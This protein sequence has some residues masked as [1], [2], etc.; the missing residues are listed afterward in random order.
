MHPEATNLPGVLESLDG[1]RDFD[2]RQVSVL[3]PTLAATSQLVV[4][5]ES[6]TAR[7]PTPLTQT[8][9]Q[10]QAQTKT[11]D[12]QT[13]RQTDAADCD[14]SQ[15]GKRAPS[16]GSSQESEDDAQSKRIR[17][18]EDD[19]H[20][21]A[22]RTR[23]SAAPAATHNAAHAALNV[24]DKAAPARGEGGKCDVNGGEGGGRPQTRHGGT[25]NSEHH[26]PTSAPD[27]GAAVRLKKEKMHSALPVP[28]AEIESKQDLTTPKS[29]F[30]V[31]DKV[32]AWFKPEKGW[33]EA[34]VAERL[35]DGGFLLDW[36]DGDEADRFKRASN[37]RHHG[38]MRSDPD[39]EPEPLPTPQKNTPKTRCMR[40]ES[41]RREESKV[42][43]ESKTECTDLVPAEHKAGKQ[44]VA[45]ASVAVKRERPH[46]DDKQDAEECVG[47]RGGQEEGASRK[48]AAP[49]RFR[50]GRESSFKCVTVQHDQHALAAYMP[51][52]GVQ[53]STKVS[54]PSHTSSAAVSGGADFFR[55]G[56]LVLVS[57]AAQSVLRNVKKAGKD[58]TEP[59]GKQALS[60][61]MGPFEVERAVSRDAVCGGE[62]GWAYRL[63]IPRGKGRV[64]FS[65]SIV[66]GDLGVHGC[67]FDAEALR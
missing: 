5:V 15:T 43:E 61:F 25:A 16:Q 22:R 54:T 7:N 24:S 50:A 21:H 18:M 64:L 9:T 67:E 59:F 58:A 41:K 11:K 35:E 66:D 6:D 57:T 52:G 65:G 4:K 19:T 36:N 40:E 49:E 48:R 47:G 63:K 37:L 14:S 34:S 2:S 27:K 29:S 42:R 8:Q 60:R 31:G 33:Y 55:A 1:V 17:T 44:T 23:H 10:T 12:A 32:W 38:K 20:H 45:H 46:D 39:D 30:Q 26:I 3:V 62:A 13:Q 53:V 56:D 51:A 28:T